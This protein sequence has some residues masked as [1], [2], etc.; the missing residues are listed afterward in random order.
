[1]ILPL[2]IILQFLIRCKFECDLSLA[3]CMSSRT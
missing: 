2:F 1:M 3:T